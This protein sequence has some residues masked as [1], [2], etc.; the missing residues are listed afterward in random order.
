MIISCNQCNK[1][2]QIDENLIPDT[3]RLL[4]CGS[5]KHKWFYKKKINENENFLLKK[6]PNEK[7]EIPINEDYVDS[8][9]KEKTSTNTTEHNNEADSVDDSVKKFNKNKKNIASKKKSILNIILV[10]V[11][12]IIALIVLID[13]FKA[14]ISLVVPDINFFLVSLYET[15]ND[16]FLFFYDLI[17]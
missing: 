2:F 1:K 9:E 10:F 3:G 6:S 4:Q 16:I 7:I 5:C 13:T 12:S 11:I 15:L 14:P 17:N 8:D